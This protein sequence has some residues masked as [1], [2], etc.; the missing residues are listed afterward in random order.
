VVS[1]PCPAPSSARTLFQMNSIRTNMIS[2]IPANNSCIRCGPIFNNTFG[3]KTRWI[4][5]ATMLRIT[6]QN[7]QGIKPVKNNTKLQSDI[8]N[9]ISL[10]SG[11]TCLTT[12]NK[13]WRNNGIRQASM[14]LVH[15]ANF[16]NHHITNMEV[17]LSQLQTDGHLGFTDQVNIPL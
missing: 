3:D 2:S 6:T 10:Q 8:G 7:V 5:P 11:I 13:E 17:L 4:D 15:Q 14:F 9:M 1:P 12:T 16:C